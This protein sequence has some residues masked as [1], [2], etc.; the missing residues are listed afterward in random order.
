M[1]DHVRSEGDAVRRRY[2]PSRPD[3]SLSEVVLRAIDSHKDD[4]LSRE[5]HR[6]YDQVDPDALD[7]LFKEDANGNLTVQFS[8]D[9]VNVSLWGD[10][11]VEVRVTDRFD[12]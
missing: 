4:A 11:T 9:G 1:D 2:D 7:N 10:G 12:R 6:L 8:Y 3:S 5:N